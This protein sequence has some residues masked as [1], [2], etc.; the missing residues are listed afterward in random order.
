MTSPSPAEYDF[1]KE[2]EYLTS[3]EAYGLSY[4]DRYLR[5]S[6]A[7]RGAMNRIAAQASMIEALVGEKDSAFTRGYAAG[8]EAGAKYCENKWLGENPN[9]V[10]A[11]LRA[12]PIPET[13]KPAIAVG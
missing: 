3:P 5:L 7:A 1:V 13:E 4:K 8:L 11:I 12:L 9:Y 2:L 10:A 6:D